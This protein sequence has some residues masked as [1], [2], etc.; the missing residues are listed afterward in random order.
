MILT[1]FDGKPVHYFHLVGRA[2]YVVR[3][4]CYAAAMFQ[5]VRSMDVV[6][7]VPPGMSYKQEVM[8]AAAALTMEVL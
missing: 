2:F 5:A 8:R 4:T 1:H 6:I 3:G 7:L